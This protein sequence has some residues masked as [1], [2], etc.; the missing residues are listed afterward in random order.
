MNK[1]KIFN[2][3][4]LINI[5]K[6][7]LVGLLLAILAIGT[8]ISVNANKNAGSVGY[9][10]E[11]TSSYGINLVKN[12]GFEIV[13]P[14]DASKPLYWYKYKTGQEGRFKYPETGRDGSSKSVGVYY[15]LAEDS[16]TMWGQTIKINSTKK[17]RLA[18]WMKISNVTRIPRIA[19]GAVLGVS[20]FDSNRKWIG[21][22]SVASKNGSS[23]WIFYEGIFKPIPGAYYADI[24]LLMPGSSGKTWFDDIYFGIANCSTSYGSNLAKNGGFEIVDS[25]DSHKPLYWNQQIFA[26]FN[27]PE[28][29][30]IGSK[31]VGIEGTFMG[32]NQRIKINA[33][34]KYRFTGWMKTSVCP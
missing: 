31:S 13:D 16:Q 24:N 8:T 28:S 18:G 32:W 20:W 22:S 15:P 7:L 21:S 14:N 3:L 25:N 30:R 6:V 29:G 4:K 11:Y 19:P 5:Y 27:Y 12:G 9:I 10:E 17:Y 26:E 33:T 1:T 34:K 2:Q 23:G